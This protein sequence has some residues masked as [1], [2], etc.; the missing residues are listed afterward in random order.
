MVT[1]L[2]FSHAIRVRGKIVH[3]KKGKFCLVIISL[4]LSFPWS[5]KI[6]VFLVLNRL[7]IDRVCPH[8]LRFMGAC[9]D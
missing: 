9:S 4:C 6:L 8:C 7:S 1:V 5:L 3:L 2:S